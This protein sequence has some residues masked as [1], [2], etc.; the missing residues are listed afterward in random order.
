MG[1]ADP[2]LLLRGNSL[3]EDY[4]TILCFPWQSLS[5]LGLPFLSV[6]SLTLPFCSPCFPSAAVCW[7][8]QPL[9]NLPVVLQTFL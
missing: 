7:S 4:V 1:E 3:G 2:S 6:P 8:A 9:H 5:I